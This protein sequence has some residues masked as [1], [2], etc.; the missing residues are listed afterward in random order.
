MSRQWPCNPVCSLCN[1]EQETAAHLVLHCSF[2]RQ[3]WERMEE[4]TQQ[5]VRLPEN[6]IEIVDWWQKE[7]VQLPKK[8]RKLKAAMMMYCAW[9]LL[10]ERNRRVFEQKIKNPAEVMQEIK[11]EVDTR[12]L[13]C[14][15][16]EFS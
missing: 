15:G 3:V 8:T 1:Q 14:G 13:A 5:L 10:K 6:G 11:L 2:A 12:K 7:L 16:P 4:W 9:N